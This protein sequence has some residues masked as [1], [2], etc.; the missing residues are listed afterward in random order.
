MDIK[1]STARDLMI[2]L[3]DSSDHITGK[4]G[5]TLTITASKNGA[6]FGSITPTVTERGNGFYS[7][8]LTTSH[9][10]TLGDLALHITGTGADPADIILQVVANFT[11]DVKSDT[12]AIISTLSTLVADI[13]AAGTRTLTSFGTL[14]ADV[15]TNGTRTLTSFGTLIADIWTSATRSLTDKANF[16]LSAAYDPAKT[17]A[18]ATNLATTDGKI[19]LIKA[20]TDNLPASPAATGDA[21][22]LTA[23]YDAAKT[24][25]Q[26]S[27]LATVDGKIDI[28]DTNIDI[29]LLRI[30]AEVANDADMQSVIAAIANIY[31]DM[32]TDADMTTVLSNLSTLLSR[33]PA[34]AA[35]DADMQT[36]LDALLGRTLIDIATKKFRRYKRAGALLQEYDLTTTALTPDTYIERNPI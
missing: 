20:K 32:A 27:A 7:L 30:P 6:A 25:A 34:A 31:S 28:I 4:T 15:W 16:T 19:D 12:A 13:W 36:A 10:D 2:F 21:M 14:A 35:L 29:L 5:L 1:Q 22:T 9:T 8:A 18:Q 33:I 26:A 17:A 24:A 3:T 11:A 23:A